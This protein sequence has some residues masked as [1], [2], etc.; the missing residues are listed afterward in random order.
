MSNV[1]VKQGPAVRTFE[2]I[3][4]AKE[5][6]VTLDAI[7]RAALDEALLEGALR[8]RAPAHVLT[9]GK[10]MRCH[11]HVWCSQAQ[12]HEPSTHST[13]NCGHGDG[14]AKATAASARKT[15]DGVERMAEWVGEVRLRTV[16]V[17]ITLLYVQ[18]W[19]AHQCRR[20]AEA[21]PAAQQDGRF[22]SPQT[23]GAHAFRITTWTD[24][25]CL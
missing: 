11:A 22:S 24:C 4:P 23:V 16:L 14:V 18:P 25:A 7:L 1:F 6:P 21:K 19:C 15:K 17:F 13:Q 5:F 20:C 3:T 10:T 2:R 9:R 12:A 8:R